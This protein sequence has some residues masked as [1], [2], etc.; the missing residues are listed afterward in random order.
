M[1]HQTDDIALPSA[2]EEAL[3]WYLRLSSEQ[4]TEKDWDAHTQ[5]LAANPA[6]LEE[7]TAVQ[8][9]FDRIDA[10]GREIGTKYQDARSSAIETSR[11]A[12]TPR[13]LGLGWALIRRRPFIAAGLVTAVLAVFIVGG[14][15]LKLTMA[16]DITRIATAIGEVRQVTLPDGS[17]ANLDTDTAL[18][19]AYT[20]NQRSTELLRGR[21]VF[22]VRHDADH[23]FIVKAADH[24]IQVLGTKFEVA[25]RDN[26]LAVA[27]ARGLVG[28]TSG[29]ESAS[30]AQLGVGEKL[31]FSGGA[32]MPVKERVDP[33]NIGS[34][35]ERRLIFDSAPLD[36][37]LGEINRY[38]AGAPFH[39]ADDT[40][41]ALQFT[42]SIYVDDEENIARNLSSF[43]SLTYERDD[44][45]FAL[46]RPTS[47][48]PGI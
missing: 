6:H 1:A 11:G 43:M 12:A 39:L 14:L 3:A 48:Q 9:T 8:A 36:H 38:F 28:V 13:S 15:S 42:G 4:A 22:D 19:V 27:V 33:E 29:K 16:P 25:S 24:V 34:W 31:V 40:L 2:S 45:G 30:A 5:W 7:F 46:K 23:P 26:R 10:V 35:T 32:A 20:G 41:A 47:D 17:Q 37:V 18:L 21:A 44:E